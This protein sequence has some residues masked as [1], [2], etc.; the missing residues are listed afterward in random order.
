M[1]AFTLKTA[2]ILCILGTVL[3]F[4]SLLAGTLSVWGALCLMPAAVLL[5]MQL[6][7]FSKQAARDARRRAARQRRPVRS[8]GAAAARTLTARR[9]PAL[10]VVGRTH[11]P[12]DPRAA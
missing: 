2:A 1:L 9:R 3:A 5:G 6:L 11:G 7:R 4:N 12:E 10:Q 8:T